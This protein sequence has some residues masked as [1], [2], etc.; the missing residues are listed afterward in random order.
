MRITVK[1]LEYFVATGEFGSIKQASIGI[2]ISQPS[3]SS[4]IAHLEKELKLQ[5]FVRHHAKGLTLTTS[6]K[7]LMREVKLLLK[8]MQD[9]YSIASDI[10]N[11]LSGEL[12]VGC[13]VTLA[14]MIAPELGHTF[15]TAKTDV[16]LNIVVGSHEKLM[17]ML[18]QVEI[19]VAIV[20]DFDVPH[21]VIYEPLTRLPP[22]V[23]LSSKHP[24]AKRSSIDL[25]ELV[26]E[27]LILLNLPHSK[28]YFLSLFESKGLAPTVSTLVTNQEVVRTMVANDYGYTI[29]NARPKNLI[30]L[31]GRKLVAVKLAG[32]HRPMKVGVATLAQANKPRILLAFEEH[33]RNMITLKN[34]PGMTSL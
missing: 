4:A 18:Q 8:Q 3:I 27:P 34:I 20:Y 6:G 23:L 13:M 16:S 14:P 26:E 25:R 5:L 1:H 30:A 31:D 19:D 2:N 9:L 17:H 33:C 29:A 12:S 15:L 10:K 28:Q 32:R 21:D 7:K 24:L 11:V 22:H